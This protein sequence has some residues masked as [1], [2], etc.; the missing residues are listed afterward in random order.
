MLLDFVNLSSLLL[1]VEAIA[2]VRSLSDGDVEIVT[3]KVKAFFNDL[4]I[5]PTTNDI[6]WCVR[7]V[8]LNFPCNKLAEYSLEAN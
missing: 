2:L 3:T 5:V 6:T 8:R 4:L 1:E 7:R